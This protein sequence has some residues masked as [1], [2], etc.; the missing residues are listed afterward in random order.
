LL[1]CVFLFL[2]ML[3]QTA[4]MILGQKNFKQIFF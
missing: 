4:K 1:E 3:R 2:F